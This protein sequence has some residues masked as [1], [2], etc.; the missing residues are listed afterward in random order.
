MCIRDRW[1]RPSVY[2]PHL[3]LVIVPCLIHFFVPLMFLRAI[4]VS[5]AAAYVGRQ[6]A[7]HYVYLAT[8][9]PFDRKT[10]AKE[11]LEWD[12][13]TIF[14]SLLVI[15]FGAA[16]VFPRFAPLLF[17]VVAAG[18]GLT[19]IAAGP[20]NLTRQLSSAW[21]SWCTYNRRDKEAPGVLK[22]PAGTA[23]ERL[24]MVVFLVASMTLLLASV[25]PLA[26]IVWGSA[27]EIF[28]AG[29]IIVGIVLTFVL[30]GLPIAVSAALVA[31]VSLPAI[32]RFAKTTTATP[33]ASDWQAV[34]DSIRS[35]SNPIE[36]DSIYI[37][38]VARDGAPLLVPR[39]VFHEHAHILGDSGSGK[40][41]RGLIPM[42]EQLLG[43][44]ESSLMVIDLKGDSQEML[45]SLN[46]CARRFGT[47]SQPIPV[48]HFST[49]EDHSTFAF[50][51]FQLPCWKHLNLY[52]RTD[53]L[54]GALGL[55]YGTDY[56]RGF[57]SSA[58]A[59]LL[60]TSP[61]PRDQRGSRMPSSA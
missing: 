31:L 45:S 60:Y 29:N 28:D 7:R 26:G 58:N 36:R 49:R 52:Q 25:G 23:N 41:A 35:S 51:P 9:F 3:A 22:S 12:E 11:R 38:R 24:G 18:C 59:C 32:I 43:D 6:F 33:R 20:I 54:C 8:S 42:A 30:V 55:T 17:V 44:R 2:K 48:R 1:Q 16:F 34:T 56:G 39:A 15:P 10:A 40:T 14:S 13:L 21:Y 27:S 46:E 61:S 5:V 19:V 50:N 4:V 53:V 57:F 37:G 47:P